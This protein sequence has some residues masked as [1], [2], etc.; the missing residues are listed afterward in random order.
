MMVDH[1]RHGR[2]LGRDRLRRR[3]VELLWQRRLVDRREEQ[4]ERRLVEADREREQP[5]REEAAAHE[6]EVDLPGDHRPARAHRRRGAPE[7]GVD[8]REAAGHHDVHERERDERL[9]EDER[10]ERVAEGRDLQEQLVDAERVGDVGDR[11]RRDEDAAEQRARPRV[12]QAAHPER[13]E[14]AE[15]ERDEARREARLHRGPERRRPRV[16]LREPVVPLQR[17]A[18]GRELEQLAAGPRRRDDDEHRQREE[19]REQPADREDRQAQRPARATQVVHDARSCSH[20]LEMP[21]M[22]SDSA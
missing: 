2:Q 18:L 14:R 6:R 7:R 12:L 9:R 21:S 10:H 19:E 1:D 22:R 8:A 13:G 3:A 11:E 15:D 4:R 16:V 20:C 17:E 5:A